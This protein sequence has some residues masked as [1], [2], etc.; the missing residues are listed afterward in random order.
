[1]C[2]SAQAFRLEP[3]N[4]I[5]GWDGDDYLILF[6]EAESKQLTEGNGVK[7]YL[8]ELTVVGILGWDDFILRDNAGELFR[9][10]TVPLLQKYIDKLG[11]IPDAARLIRE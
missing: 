3:K 10:P 7:K 6:D 9:V 4:L 5:E 11:Q 2:R 8:P 1:V